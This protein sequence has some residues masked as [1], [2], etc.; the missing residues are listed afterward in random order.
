MEKF[1]EIA[2]DLGF[3][4]AAAAPADRPREMEHFENWL[5][6]GFE[7]EMAYLKNNRERIANPAG[8][9][10]NA[11]SILCVG[12]HFHRDSGSFREG[13]RV[14]R[15]ALGRDYHHVLGR[16]LERLK[17]ALVQSGILRSSRSVVDAGP[18]LERSHA[19][20]AGLGFFSKSGNVLHPQYGPWFFLAELVTQAP[21]PYS[22]EKFLGSCGTCRA[23]IDACPTQAIRE[24]FVVDARLCISYLTI[25]HRSEIPVQLRPLIGDWVFGCD[26]CSEVCPFGWKAPQ[27]PERFGT[28]PAIEK[29]R[30]LDLLDLPEEN[31]SKTFE[32]SPMRRPKWR[33]M[34]RNL[35]V[36]LGNR[37]KDEEALPAVRKKLS[38]SDPL[39]RRHAAW[40][41]GRWGQKRDLEFAKNREIDPEVRMEIT[42]AL[43]V[44][45]I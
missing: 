18:L 6:R 23:C 1:E 7:G 25:E 31:F 17:K 45:K 36:V 15:Y 24:P 21:L 28:H 12:Y 11:K 4:L 35:L 30:L 34:I 14:S 8:L 41:L 3:D 2:K 10:E 26:V 32:G 19:V 42:Q 44:E 40:T 29:F 5:D 37:E 27:A 22:K 13:G 38:H 33:G 16:L 9:L 20:Q 43:E 39:L